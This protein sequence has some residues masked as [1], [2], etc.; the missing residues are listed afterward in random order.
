MC[1]RSASLLLADIVER[2]L[3]SYYVHQANH[4]FNEAGAA[5]MNAD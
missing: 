5:A 1:L 2:G 4:A 3:H